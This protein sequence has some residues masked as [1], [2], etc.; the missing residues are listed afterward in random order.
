MRVKVQRPVPGQQGL[1]GQGLP[2]AGDEIGT[3]LGACCS[4]LFV[5]NWRKKAFFYSSQPFKYVHVSVP[6]LH[7]FLFFF[8]FLIV[9]FWHA[10]FLEA[11]AITVYSLRTQ[12]L[13]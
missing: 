11:G 13:C 10:V 6:L 4:S 1:S 9:I 3:G 8:F 7:V 2:L 12:C 5:I